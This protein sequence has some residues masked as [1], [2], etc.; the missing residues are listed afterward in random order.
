MYD[1]VSILLNMIG[2][3]AMPYYTYGVKILSLHGV[4]HCKAQG[5]NSRSNLWNSKQLAMR[6]LQV[7][8]FSNISG[9]S[10]RNDYFAFS[11][12]WIYLTKG[13]TEQ[14]LWLCCDMSF[15]CLATVR[16]HL[17]LQ[18]PVI[19]NHVFAVSKTVQDVKI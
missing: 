12:C 10:L 14:K 2:T 17:S 7:L 15:Q 13:T 8:D 16:Y 19:S 6:L 18:H 4:E 9:F 11:S 5:L 1:G 3:T